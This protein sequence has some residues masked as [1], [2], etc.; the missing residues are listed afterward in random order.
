M[1]PPSREELIAGLEDAELVLRPGDQW[2]YSNLVFG[3]LGDVVMRVGGGT[4]AEILQQRILDPLGLGRTSLAPGD[5]VAVP[6]F[7]HPY[8]EV[9]LEEADIPLA[10]PVGAA[11]WLWST[12]SDL[13]RFGMFLADG[14][15]RV[16]A[17]AELDRMARVQTMV[18]ADRWALAWGLGLEL[19][20]RG[21]R[22]FAGHGGA[23]PGFL[24][25]LV[26]QRKERTGAAVLTNTG[27]GAA[28]EALAL[29]LAGAVLD[30]LPRT[31]D[32]WIPADAVPLELEGILGL[33]WTEGN[34]IVLAVR[35]G[36]FVA[37]L[38]DGPPGRNLSTLEPDG[39]DRWR[40]VEGRERGELLRAVRGE[41]GGVEKL[42]LATYPLTRAPATFA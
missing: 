12:P 20:R 2:H 5:P 41:D 11:G 36:R 26:V 1:E 29:D 13:A 35:S 27:A 32:R 30:A 31:P 15:E 14:D 22:V 10:E 23:M 6:Y 9:A 17:R 40:V 4:Y 3:L 21:D 7:V 33:W 28:P 8:S 37:E 25:G 42:Y 18:D 39:T 16:L 38:V 19:Y 24:A 34:Q